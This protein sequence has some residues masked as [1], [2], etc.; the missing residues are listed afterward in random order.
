MPGVITRFKKIFLLRKPVNNLKVYI[1]SWIII[2]TISRSSGRRVFF[3]KNTNHVIRNLHDITISC[4]MWGCVYEGMEVGGGRP[5]PF[6]VPCGPSTP[7]PLNNLP[8]NLQ[9]FLT[10]E[11]L[12]CRIEQFDSENTPRYTKMIIGDC[13][14]SKRTLRFQTDLKVKQRLCELWSLNTPLLFW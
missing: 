7:Q 6:S 13:I 10:V 14:D 9:I 1:K 5:A 8:Q 12:S 11:I 3:F 2:I 4:E